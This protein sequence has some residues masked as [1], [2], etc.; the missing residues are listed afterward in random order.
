MILYLDRISAMFTMSAA[1][2]SAAILC[3]IWKNF[4]F[5]KNCAFSLPSL[6]T[7]IGSLIEVTI[8]FFLNFLL[9]DD[10]CLIFSRRGLMNWTSNYNRFSK[11]TPTKRSAS[12]HPDIFYWFLDTLVWPNGCIISMLVLSTAVKK[13]MLFICRYYKWCFLSYIQT[14]GSDERPILDFIWI[15]LYGL[16]LFTACVLRFQYWISFFSK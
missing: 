14:V 2:C 15:H 6:V 5:I 12:M 8:L 9:P 7:W 3:C 4:V 13:V 11:A 16:L 1:E 10:N